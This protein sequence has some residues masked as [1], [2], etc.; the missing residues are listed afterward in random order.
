MSGVWHARPIRALRLSAR[1]RRALLAHAAAT[2]AIE[3]CGLL[4]GRGARA[5]SIYRVRN[6][7]ARPAIEF[8]M[9]PASQIAALREMRRRGERLVG[10]YH[11]HPRGPARPSARDLAE[12]AYPGVAYLILSLARRTAPRIAAFRFDGQ[13]F[14]PLRLLAPR[15]GE[16]VRIVRRR[17]GALVPR[18]GTG[19]AGTARVSS[20][21]ARC[22]H[23]TARSSH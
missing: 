22:R 23:S 7:A 13:A 5:T 11:S 20:A 1:Q 14:R 12:A 15:A 21:S 6:A 8:E 2:P 3:V 10:I 19:Q 9:E 18:R 16:E 17:G 4:G